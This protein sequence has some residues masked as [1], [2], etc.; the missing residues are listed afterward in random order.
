MKEIYIVLTHTG[1]VLSRVIRLFTGAEFSH[2]SI[3]LDAELK[4]MYSFGRLNPK[5]PFIGGFVHESPQHGTFGRF[6][7][8][9]TAIDAIRVTNE[10]Y[11]DIREIIDDIRIFRSG[12]KFNVAGMFAAGLHVKIKRDNAFYCAEF[13]RHVIER[14]GINL[15]L[16]DAVRPEDF[17]FIYGS[18]KI[19][20][21]LLRK[22]RCFFAASA[23]E[24]LF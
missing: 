18:K 21:G 2:C 3:A 4:E 17:K 11:D 6:T 15:Y 5:N 13:T 19:Y 20:S 22:Y 24:I 9:Y 7:N 14:A 23:G 12:Y 8:T 1:T 10:Q 16:P